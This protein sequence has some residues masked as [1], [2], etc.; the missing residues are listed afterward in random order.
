MEVKLLCLKN[1]KKSNCSFILF[2]QVYTAKAF[3]FTLIQ[4][5]P[6]I[7]LLMVYPSGVLNFSAGTEAFSST[8]TAFFIIVPYL[9]FVSWYN[10]TF[11]QPAKTVGYSPEFI[12]YDSQSFPATFIFEPFLT[13][14]SLSALDI[15]FQSNL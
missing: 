3:L 1:G 11:C 9:L 13:L 6:Y 4:P 5:P 10:S 8:L 15:S 7:P 14:Y 2:N 12:E